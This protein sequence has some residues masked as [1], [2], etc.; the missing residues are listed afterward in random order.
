M[1]IDIM[2]A[3][4]TG[5]SLRGAPYLAS[6]ACYVACTI[7]V[8]NAALG[9]SKSEVCRNAQE[10]LDRT[11]T[12]LKEL[13]DASPCAMRAVQII[14]RLMSANQLQGIAEPTTDLSPSSALDADAIIRMFPRTPIAPNFDFSQLDFSNLEESAQNQ[15]LGLSDDLI[16]YDPL[17]GFMDGFD[18]HG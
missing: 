15:A 13:S 17:F 9:N 4:R 5:Y 1:I 18:V 14:Q 8:R 10:M 11:L 6:Y 16:L 7:H 12:M 2:T 3:Y